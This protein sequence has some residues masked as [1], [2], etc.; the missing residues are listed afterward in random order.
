MPRYSAD[1]HA[2]EFLEYVPNKIERTGPLALLSSL[3]S[4]SRCL[5]RSIPLIPARLSALA[6][7]IVF[8][9]APVCPCC[10]AKRKDDGT[11]VALKKISVP[12]MDKKSRTKCM[13]EVGGLTTG[14]KCLTYISKSYFWSAWGCSPC[15]HKTLRN[16]C[17]G[18]EMGRQNTHDFI[19]RPSPDRK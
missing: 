9:V 1:Q 8:V 19:V 7:R 13:R 2:G 17:A 10:R 4:L 16:Q 14:V 15:Q 3:S 18:D 5:S 12:A 6:V 11:N